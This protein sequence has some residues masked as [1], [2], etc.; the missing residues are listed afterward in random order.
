MRAQAPATRSARAIQ[1]RLRLDGIRD[2]TAGHTPERPIRH[3]GTP[4]PIH[5]DAGLDLDALDEKRQPKLPW[6][7]T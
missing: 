5:G 1:W 3:T 4:R 7:N 6:E 2:V